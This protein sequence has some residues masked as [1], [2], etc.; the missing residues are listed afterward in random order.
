MASGNTLGA[1]YWSDS[2]V[3]APMMRGA[4]P[5]FKCDSCGSFFLTAN[6]PERYSNK[7]FGELGVFGFDEL[8]AAREQFEKEGTAIDR[9]FRILQVYGYNDKFF[10]NRCGEKL[11]PSAEDVAYFRMVVDE[12]LQQPAGCDPILVAEL[13]RETGR[14]EE[15]IAQLDRYKDGP[16][17][18]IAQL[19]RAAALRGEHRVF[20]LEG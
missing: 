6:Q 8:K 16:H 2:K 10:R 7:E 13:N 18:D 19:I 15:C 9:R 20:D 11:T 1:I 3:E 14:F 4:S 12:I 17:A 5:V